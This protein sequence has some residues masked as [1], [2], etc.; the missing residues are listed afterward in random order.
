MKNKHNNINISGLS[1]NN[2]DSNN[3]NLNNNVSNNPDFNSVEFEVKIEDL[4]NL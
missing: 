4:K 1:N 3:N 2:N